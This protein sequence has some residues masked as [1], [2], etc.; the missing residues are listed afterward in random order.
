[1][2]KLVLLRH[3]QSLFN[4]EGRFTGWMDIDL[5]ERG[6]AEAGEAGWLMKSS[7]LSFDI[8]FTSVLKRAIR[9][10]WIVLDE[11][12]LMW[13]PALPCWRLNERFYGDLQ[14]K[15]KHEM[16]KRYG[17]A[18]VRLWRRSF[19]ERPPVV[20]KD[21]DRYPGMDAR[22]RD[23]QES[24]LPRTESLQDTQE[25]MLPFWRALIAPELQKGKNVLV[26]SHGNTIRALVKHLEDI[27]DQEIENVE[28]A[29]AQP[30][31]YELDDQ[32]RLVGRRYL[33]S[34]QASRQKESKK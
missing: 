5:S 14:G 32:M 21:D 18:Q 10:M 6:K 12:D 2:A 17:A 23:V 25:R 29:T 27:S 33:G 34:A 8:A 15:S 30:L 16:E 9:T 11:M 19:S 22:Y 26:V 1:M 24:L 28:I 4:Q 3:G 13:I 7:G 20:A 31:V